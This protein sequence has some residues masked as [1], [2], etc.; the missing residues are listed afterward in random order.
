M[1]QF[2]LNKSK[3]P[4]EVNG[5]LCVWPGTLVSEDQYE[6]FKSFIK[7]ES[8]TPIEV[9]CIGQYESNNVIGKGKEKANSQDFFFVISGDIGGIVIPRLSIGFKWFDDF[10]DNNP[11]FQYK[12]G[13][14]WVTLNEL[15]YDEE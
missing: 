9:E 13:D 8:K 11:E 6:D 1:T 10:R 4:V 5:V 15:V 2:I 12:I 3:T 7:G 14:E